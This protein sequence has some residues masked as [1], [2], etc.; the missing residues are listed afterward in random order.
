MEGVRAGGREDEEEDE[1]EKEE[2]RVFH[3][4]KEKGAD[5]Q[6]FSSRRWKQ[7]RIPFPSLKLKGSKTT[8]PSFRKRK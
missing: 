7:N 6:T 4:L 1:E 3:P 2:E 8:F 5:Q